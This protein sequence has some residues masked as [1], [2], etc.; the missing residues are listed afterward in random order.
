MYR[1]KVVCYIYDD[2]VDFKKLKIYPV[3]V[4]EYLD[5]YNYIDCL[6]IDKNSVPDVNVISMS[7]LD[8]L[9]SIS[10]GSNYYSSKMIL[11]LKL[12]LHLRDF[13][14]ITEDE[15]RVIYESGKNLLL[16]KLESPEKDED[17]IVINRSGNK[18]WDEISKIIKD[19]FPDGMFYFDEG[20]IIQ[21][22][23]KKNKSMIQIKD[24]FYSSEDFDEIKKIIL[25][26]NDVEEIDEQVRKEYR[27]ELERARIRANNANSKDKMCDFENQMI[28]VSVALCCSLDEVKEF[29]IRKFKKY[30]ARIN[31]KMTYE[32][33]KPAI[34]SGNITSKDKGFPSFWMADLESE[35]KYSGVLVEEDD[36]NKK[37]Q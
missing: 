13:A 3:K 10:D 29:T 34:L 11:L 25:E 14:I 6:Q 24:G 12:C 31:H 18:S 2:P 5:F 1:Q 16:S 28:C 19:E 4:S 36:V 30:I 26:Q 37:L 17:V 20:D 21:I 22:V 15:A 35:S 7:Y 33:F 9:I 23:K 27:D 8:Y 32:I